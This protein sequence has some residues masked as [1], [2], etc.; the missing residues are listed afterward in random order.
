M[1][2]E[3]KMIAQPFELGYEINSRYR[4]ATTKARL[5]PLLGATLSSLSTRMTSWPDYGTTIIK[6]PRHISTASGVTTL[7]GTSHHWRIIP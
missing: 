5:E 3:N 1:L 2:S 4:I 6:K 7:S